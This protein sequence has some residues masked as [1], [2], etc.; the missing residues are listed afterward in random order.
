[1]AGFGWKVVVEAFGALFCGSK[2]SFYVVAL[3]KGLMDPL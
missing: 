1:L 3:S 2:P